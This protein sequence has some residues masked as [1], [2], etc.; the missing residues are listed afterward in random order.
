[1]GV[2]IGVLVLLMFTIRALGLFDRLMQRRQTA[3]AIL[4]GPAG[5]IAT[6]ET[7]SSGSGSRDAARAGEIVAVIAAALALAEDDESRTSPG[8]T[9]RPASTYPDAWAAAGRRQLMDRRGRPSR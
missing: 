7:P 3:V 6:S 5:S 9:G 4:E 8:I 2:T 1:M